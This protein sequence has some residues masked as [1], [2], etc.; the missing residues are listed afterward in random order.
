MLST[1]LSRRRWARLKRTYQLYLMLLPVVLY[2]AL[3][4]Y[5]PMYGIQIGFKDYKA[6]FGVSGSIWVGFSAFDRFFSSYYA[7]R[8]IR[9]TI[10]L[11]SLSLLFCFP[12]PIL[13]ALMISELKWSKFKKTVQ[14][15][16]YA[17]HFLSITVVVGMVRL[18]LATQ[19]GLINNI[20]A[21]AG[22]ERIAFLTDSK[23]FLPIYILSDVWQQTGWNSVIYIAAIAGIDYS[24]YEAAYLDGATI[25]KRIWYVTLPCIAPTV[26]VM[27]ILKMGSL[28]N[29]GFEKVW[30]MQNDLNRES[31]DVISTYVYR[32]GL[33][34][35]DYS[36][37][38]AINLFSN[39]INFLILITVN[40][41]SRK[42][43]ETSLW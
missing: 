18:L 4:K 35:S 14:M 42:I 39:V 3:F 12:T 27:L 36:Y 29:V 2:F 41:L 38:S 10:T 32:S 5:W 7:I 40:M 30:L 8:L 24:L 22:H 23:W 13:L 6:A 19:T 20:L 15:V 9:N 28:M 11:S 1:K 43:S 26:I 16:T 21:S 25:V 31:S 33:T 34:Q 37:S 17:P